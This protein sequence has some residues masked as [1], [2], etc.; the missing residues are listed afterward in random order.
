[1]A[2]HALT[3]EEQLAQL[4]AKLGKGVGATAQRAKLAGTFKRKHRYDQWKSDVHRALSRGEPY[5]EP[6]KN[7]WS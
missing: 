5:P 3:P 4:D 2:W 6:P 7:L 1:M